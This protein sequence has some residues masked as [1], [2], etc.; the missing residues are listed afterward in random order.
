MSQTKA[1]GWT[2][3]CASQPDHP[4]NQALPGLNHPI[5]FIDFGT[6]VPRPTALAST[7]ARPRGTK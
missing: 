3:G 7:L 5:P 4:A 1:K 2:D 6:I